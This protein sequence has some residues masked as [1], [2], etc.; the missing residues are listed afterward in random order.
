MNQNSP[1]ALALEV[2][3]VGAE[4]ASATADTSVAATTQRAATIP[5]PSPNAGSKSCFSDLI[6]KYP[7]L[8]IF[9]PLGGLLT[10]AAPLVIGGFFLAKAILLTNASHPVAGWPLFGVGA[11]AGLILFGL[12]VKG[13]LDYYHIRTNAPSNQAIY[14]STESIISG[15]SSSSA[16]SQR[17]S[18]ANKGES[19]RR[20]QRIQR[21]TQRPPLAVAHGSIGALFV[22]GSPQAHTP[23]QGQESNAADRELKRPKPMSPQT[24]QRQPVQRTPIGEAYTNISILFENPTL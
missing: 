21:P 22:P 8:R 11:F 2:P 5:S 23:S 17:S 15:I 19:R 10:I 20:N 12:L 14:S 1:L 6:D 7:S 9:L 24:G 18:P 13:C 4:A 16:Q 3:F